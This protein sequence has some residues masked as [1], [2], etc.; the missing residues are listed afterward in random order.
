M[1]TNISGLKAMLEKNIRN[2][3]NNE[4]MTLRKT[5]FIFSLIDL[6]RQFALLR[7]RRGQYL[8]A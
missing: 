6:Y 5:S 8:K 4:K 3:K 7:L 1:Q 2:D